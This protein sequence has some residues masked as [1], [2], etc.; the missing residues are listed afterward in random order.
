M[1]TNMLVCR[2]DLS[3]VPPLEQTSHFMKCD[4]RDLSWKICFREIQ[5][6]KFWHLYYK[7]LCFFWPVFIVR[8]KLGHIPNFKVTFRN[9]NINTEKKSR[10]T[11]Y[12]H[13]SMGASF[14]MAFLWFLFLK[15]PSM[16]IKYVTIILFEQEPSNPNKYPGDSW[17]WASVLHHIFLQLLFSITLAITHVSVW[18][19]A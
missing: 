19:V 7:M 14:S 8:K 5:Y 6:I 16:S 10:T 17:Y 12:F 2:S 18:F 11:D 13:F 3:Y 9:N 15:F 4:C 1:N